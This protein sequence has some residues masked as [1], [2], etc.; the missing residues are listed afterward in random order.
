MTERSRI[1]ETTGRAVVT[2]QTAAYAPREIFSFGVREFDNMSQ[3]IGAGEVTIIAA[4]TGAGKTAMGLHI[5][6]YHAAQGRNVLYVLKEMTPGDTL[7]R[8][9][10]SD[11]GIPWKNIR[12]AKT[13]GRELSEAQQQAV[14]ASFA[15]WNDVLQNSGFKIWDKRKKE[16]TPQAVVRE[17]RRVRNAKE[18]ANGAVPIPFWDIVIIDYWGV[19]VP[20]GG[21]D[22]LTIANETASGLE[23]GADYSR[24]AAVVLTQL[25]R[26]ALSMVDAPVALRMDLIQGSTVLGHKSWRTLFLDRTYNV[27]M[28]NGQPTFKRV[29][30]SA[31]MGE[32][33]NRIENAFEA[34]V[35]VTYFA[36]LY[37]DDAHEKLRKHFVREDLNKRTRV[38]APS[39][40]EMEQA[41]LYAD[42]ALRNHLR[43][44]QGVNT[45]KPDAAAQEEEDEKPAPKKRRKGGA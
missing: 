24:C 39:R 34:R 16:I 21:R 42:N 44:L 32:A 20:N 33:K 13:P 19:L 18:V 5:A 11:T 29:P 40:F 25:G 6:R 35:A 26:E 37:G 43:Q 8:L 30:F 17:V 36:G 9:A 23:D 22:S 27:A 3:G 4:K 28:E 45:G 10:E 12:Y 2:G 31:T 14:E 15:Y 38:G 1:D 41:E 7:E